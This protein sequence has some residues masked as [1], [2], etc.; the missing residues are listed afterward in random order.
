MSSES[1]KG[2]TSK[3][4]R[5]DIDRKCDQSS[6]QGGVD[7]APPRF[8]SRAYLSLRRPPPVARAAVRSALPCTLPPRVRGRVQPRCRR[9]HR[10]RQSVSSMKL[11]ITQDGTKADVST[12]GETASLWMHCLQSAS[13]NESPSSASRWASGG[14][15]RS[16]ATGDC[17]GRHRLCESADRDPLNR[18]MLSG[19]WSSGS[20]RLN[21]GTPRGRPKRLRR[22]V[23]TRDRRSLEPL[24]SEVIHYER[25]AS[26]SVTD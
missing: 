9:R 1:S 13:W 8:H 3:R 10:R 2:E 22:F 20:V 7:V 14:A 23:M 6:L 15:L 25:S 16:E 18:S 24:D 17:D 11:T 5:E 4:L 21:H 12:P 26:A 19:R